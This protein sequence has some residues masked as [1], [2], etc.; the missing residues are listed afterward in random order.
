[1]STHDNSHK[2]GALYSIGLIVLIALL[3]VL[4]TSAMGQEGA[5]IV[6]QWSKLQAPPP[7]PD[8]AAP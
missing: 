6:E 4:V 3:A 5:T 8:A 2:T 1:M 7:A